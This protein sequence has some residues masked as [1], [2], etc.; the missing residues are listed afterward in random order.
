MKADF[1][2]LQLPNV[3]TLMTMEN[4]MKKSASIEALVPDKDE[5]TYSP[6]QAWKDRHEFHLCHFDDDE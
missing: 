6:I 4:E 1:L 2:D 5:N 3:S